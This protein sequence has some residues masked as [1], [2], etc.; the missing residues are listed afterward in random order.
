MG[1]AVLRPQARDHLQLLV[2]DAPAVLLLQSDGGEV[3]VAEPEAHAHDDPSPGDDVQTR[4]VLG[5]GERWQQKQRDGIHRD[6]DPLRR[7]H[8]RGQQH[9]RIE[10]V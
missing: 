2:G 7:H 8:H 5:P 6:A 4:E 3:L 10:G 1:D 9:E